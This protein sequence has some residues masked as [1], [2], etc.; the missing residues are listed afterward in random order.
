MQARF[1]QLQKFFDSGALGM[2]QN[3]LIQVRDAGS[4]ALPDRAKC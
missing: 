4:V 1:G 3:G 2:T